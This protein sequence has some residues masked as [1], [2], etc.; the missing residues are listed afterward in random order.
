MIYATSGSHLPSLPWGLC[1]RKEKNGNTTL[2]LA[3]FDWPKDGKLVVTGLNNPVTAAKL[4]ANGSKLKTAPS[5][6]GLI[7]T[8]PAKAPDAIASVIKV[9]VKGILENVNLAPKKKMKSG[10]LD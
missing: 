4:L 6:N 1:T 7:I 5:D 10:E 8:V 3:V 2:Y 9:E